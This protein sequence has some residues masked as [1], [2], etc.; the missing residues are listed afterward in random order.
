MFGNETDVP[1]NNVIHSSETISAIQLMKE[2]GKS[3][4]YHNELVPC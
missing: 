1:V 2:S 3:N 4:V